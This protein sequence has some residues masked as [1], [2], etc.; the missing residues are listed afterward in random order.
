MPIRRY[1]QVK[2]VD[3]FIY[4]GSKIV[5]SCSSDP[6]IICRLQQAHSAFGRISLVEWED[7]HAHE[8]AHFQL[9]CV[10]GIQ[11][12][13]HVTD[14]EVYERAGCSIPISAV[15][16]R[17]RLWLLGH[18]PRLGDG[19]SA[20]QALSAS[21]HPPARGQHRTRGRPRL[22]WTSQ[23]ATTRPLATLIAPAQDPP[24]QSL[25]NCKR[26]LRLFCKRLLPL[27]GED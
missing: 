8:D 11:C 2:V 14:D 1:E 19:T 26:L 3:K 17:G 16:R 10:L 6:E 27:S 15:I 21:A 20:K 22:S 4:L 13:H 23:V 5:S 18:V 24:P 9:M 12:F 7:P 25:F